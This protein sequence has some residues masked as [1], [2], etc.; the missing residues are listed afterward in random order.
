MGLESDDDEQ[1]KN[2][3]SSSSAKL[4]IP[5]D[6]PNVEDQLRVLAGAIDKKLAECQ[7]L[8]KSKPKAGAKFVYNKAEADVKTVAV[9]PRARFEVYVDH[10]L[11]QVYLGGQT[12]IS[13]LLTTLGFTEASANATI[14]VSERHVM[15][16]QRFIK[17]NVEKEIFTPLINRLS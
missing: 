2:Q 10:I 6:L 1:Q 11:N 17:R 13:K 5:K 12:P 3:W 8:I 9:D 4:P 14:E 16:L 15:S 7:K